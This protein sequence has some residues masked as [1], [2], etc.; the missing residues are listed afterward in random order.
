MAKAKI[1]RTAVVDPKAKLS[2]GVVIGPYCIVGKQVKLGKN[3]KLIS[4]VNIQATR[5][6]AGCIVFPFATIGLPPQDA[7]YKG[8]K[9]KV[10]IGDNNIIR[11]YVSIQRASVDGERKTRIGND[12]FLMAYAHVAHDFSHSLS[13][14]LVCRRTGSAT[15]MPAFRCAP[16]SGAS[17]RL[18]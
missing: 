18:R 6:G 10:R 11:E 12:N 2:E 14:F 16:R 13:R 15:K 17:N 4:N 3:T 9:T 8:E 1:H 5:M 7:K